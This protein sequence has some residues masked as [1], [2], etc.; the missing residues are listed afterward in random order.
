MTLSRDVH[1]REEIQMLGHLL[2]EPEKCSVAILLLFHKNWIIVS[3]YIAWHFIA[4]LTQHAVPNRR[5]QGTKI[6]DFFAKHY[7]FP[8]LIQISI[9]HLQLQIDIVKEPQYLNSLQN[10]IIC[11]FEFDFFLIS[12]PHPQLRIDNRHCQGTIIFYFLANP[13]YLPSLIQIS[14]PHLQLRI[15]IVKE[16]REI[17]ALQ[18]FPELTAILHRATITLPLARPLF[19]HHHF[20]L[21]H[22]AN[23]LKPVYPKI[24]TTILIT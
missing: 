13:Y 14:I 23:T 3:P 2:Q 16:P 5:C 10:I 1:Q 8:F 15:D 6:F 4:F 17:F 9:P 24:S 22:Q 20:V 19:C 11:Q 12:I 18:I 21:H 7:Y